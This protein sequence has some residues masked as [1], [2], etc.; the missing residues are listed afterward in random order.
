VLLPFDNGGYIYY[1]FIR[2]INTTE[3]ALAIS[4]RVILTYY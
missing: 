2:E 4:N 1:T 3:I